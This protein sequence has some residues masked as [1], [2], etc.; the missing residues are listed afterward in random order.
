MQFIACASL[1]ISDWHRL[2]VLRELKIAL[3]EAVKLEKPLADEK[4]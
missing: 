1:N 4:R 3:Y 2:A